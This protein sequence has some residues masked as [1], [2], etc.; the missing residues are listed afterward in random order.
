MAEKP[1]HEEDEIYYIELQDVS[2]PNENLHSGPVLPIQNDILQQ[3]SKQKLTKV[4]RPISILFTGPPGVGKS[5]L[6]N[7]MLGK[8]VARTDNGP[9][10]IKADRDHYEGEFENVRLE[11]Y[12]TDGYS[13]KT[14]KLIYSV[15]ST[16]KNFDLIL[17]CIKINNRIGDN[18]TNMLQALAK[19][20]DK[21][22]WKRAIIVFTFVNCLTQDLKI[23][24]LKTEEAK[25]EEVQKTVD[26]YKKCI[27]KHLEDHLGHET[28]SDIPFCL[29]GESDPYDPTARDARKLPTTDDWLV[30]LWATCAIRI[31]PEVRT[32]FDLLKAFILHILL[33]INNRGIKSKSF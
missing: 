20:L 11:V 25:Y 15:L 9:D 28:A 7:V 1:E 18:E 17:I 5:T 2:Q 23:K 24:R 22:A 13:K 31:N 19:A 8:I 33:S 16:R 4:K 14:R 26:E 32:W 30:D 27:S 6:V 29:A 3:E 12:D 21:E 10:S